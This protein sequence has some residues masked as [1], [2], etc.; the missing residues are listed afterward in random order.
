MTILADFLRDSNGIVHRIY[1]NDTGEL[2]I[3]TD[4]WDDGWTD[5]S[6]TIPTMNADYRTLADSSGTTWY[7]YVTTNGEIVITT[8]APTANAGIWEDPVYGAIAPE[9]SATGNEIYWALQSIT[10][11]EWFVYPN[12]LGELIITTIEP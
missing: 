11:T 2:V 12:D 5:P 1:P 6:Y 7:I 10:S 3:S 4:L 9:A 8:T